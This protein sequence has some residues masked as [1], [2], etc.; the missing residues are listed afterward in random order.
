MVKHL[1]INVLF[2][3]LFGG[4]VEVTPIPLCEQRGKTSL[5][6]K[7]GEVTCKRCLQRIRDRKHVDERFGRRKVIS[8]L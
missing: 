4:F 3:P 6:K 5:T 2:P 1:S 8:Y 7:V